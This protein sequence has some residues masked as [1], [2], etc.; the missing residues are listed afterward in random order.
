MRTHEMA[1]QTRAVQTEIPTTVRAS[2][3]LKEERKWGIAAMGGEAEAEA[4]AEI[5][6]ERGAEERESER[7]GM[8]ICVLTLLR[9]EVC[10][11]DGKLYIHI[12]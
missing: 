5:E 7:G 12:N 4:E 6:R 10:V 1:S 3:Y 2:P 9:W 8:L 11:R